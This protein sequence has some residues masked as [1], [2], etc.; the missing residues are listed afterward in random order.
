MVKMRVLLHNEEGVYAFHAIPQLK[1]IAS[2]D[3]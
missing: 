2:S 1:A 3:R